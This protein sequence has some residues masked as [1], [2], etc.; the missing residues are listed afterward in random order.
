MRT[1]TSACKKLWPE[2]AVECVFE[3]FQTVPVEPAINEMVSLAKIMG[4]EV[5]AYFSSISGDARD[6]GDGHDGVHGGGVGHNG[7]HGDGGDRDDDH[8]DGDGEPL[9]HKRLQNWH[10]CKAERRR[11]RQREVQRISE[12]K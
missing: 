6:D 8:G 3:E 4:L 5:D 7:H 9:Q 11:W 2:C 10:T 12:I 1:L